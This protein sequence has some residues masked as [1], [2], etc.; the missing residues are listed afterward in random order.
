MS[1][2]RRRLPKGMLEKMERQAEL[3]ESQIV[4]KPE[5]TVKGKQNRYRLI[6]VNSLISIDPS[7][8]V[9]AESITGGLLLKRQNR[10]LEILRDS[11][12]AR[13]ITVGLQD[14]YLAKDGKLVEVELGGI[15]DI[16]LRRKTNSKDYLLSRDTDGRF[17]MNLKIIENNRSI[18]RF[19]G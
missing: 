11:Q 6:I 15:L 10:V 19:F 16:G 8:Y 12:D 7:E 14:Y 2:K 9:E 3:L 5:M 4:K 18:E 1:S 17:I 13:V